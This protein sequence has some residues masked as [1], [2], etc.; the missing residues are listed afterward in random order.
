[1]NVENAPVNNAPTAV[2][3]SNVTNGTTPLSV[4]FNG[5]NSFDNDGSIV[6]YLM[7]FWRD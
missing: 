5:E 1:M 4:E 6:S 2:I 7:D 3:N